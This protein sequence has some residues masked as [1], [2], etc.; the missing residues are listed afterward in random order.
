MNYDYIKHSHLGI[1]GIII[2]NNEILLINK[3]SGPYKGK[4]DLPGGSMNFGETPTQTLEREILEETGL[5]VKSYKLYNVFSVVVDW[6]C[7]NKKIKVHHTAITYKIKNY[8]NKVLENIE[9]NEIN[10]DSSG[11]KFYDIKKLNQND[12]SEIAKIVLLGI[13]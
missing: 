13:K 7:E 10:N 1:Y 11:A 6:A 2:K 4:L 3:E 5:K 8:E 9:I 12:L